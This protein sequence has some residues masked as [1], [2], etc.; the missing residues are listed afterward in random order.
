M[1]N[2]LLSFGFFPHQGSSSEAVQ[3]VRDMEKFLGVSPKAL[4][5]SQGV[6]T[7]CGVI[8]KAFILFLKETKDQVFEIDAP[9]AIDFLMNEW[10]YEEIS[11]E[12]MLVVNSSLI[13][14]RCELGLKQIYPEEEVVWMT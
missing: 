3:V 5:W 4:L 14:K 2:V 12:K 13:T 1:S 6:K 11:I 7:N 8:P 9:G 10:E